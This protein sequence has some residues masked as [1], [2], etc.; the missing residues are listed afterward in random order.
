[1]TTSVEK[2]VNGRAVASPE[3]RFDPVALAEA[4]AIRTRA[5]AEADA[6]RAEAAGKADA[7]R[8]LAAEQARALEL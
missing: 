3:P 4:E 7:E 6:I 1:M 5:A 2:Q 8:A